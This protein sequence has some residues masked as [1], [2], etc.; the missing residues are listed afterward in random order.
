MPVAYRQGL[1][2]LLFLAAPWTAPGTAF[3]QMSAEMGAMS[4]PTCT[5]PVAPTGELTT[6]SQPVVLQAA[7]N[8]S[9]V[10]AARIEVGQ[11]ARV[12]LLPTPQVHYALLPEKP[13]GSVSY[14]GIIGLRI[15]EAGHYR[16]AS[17]SSAWLDLVRDGKAAVSTAH[18][19]GPACSGIHKMVDFVLQP[20]DYTLQVSASGEQQTIFLIAHLP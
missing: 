13:G 8:S 15:P 10:A 5:G 12:T 18:G 1:L 4:A 7:G 20:G 6:W 9:H 17:G 14:G 16:L 3:A 19:H 2:T 11:A